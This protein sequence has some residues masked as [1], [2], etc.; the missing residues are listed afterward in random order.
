[1]AVKYM[2]DSD[3]EWRKRL[4]EEREQMRKEYGSATRTVRICA[5]CGHALAI[6]HRGYHGAEEIKCPK[7]KFQNFFTPVQF[8]IA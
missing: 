5:R 6:L 3:P 8:R 1:M 7:C 2:E 4:E